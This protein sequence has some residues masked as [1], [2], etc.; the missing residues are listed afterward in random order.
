MVT[1][2]NAV[3][4]LGD[5]LYTLQPIHQYLETPLTAAEET[6]D[7]VRTILVADRGIAYQMFE[8]TFPT[9]QIYDDIDKAI[10]S[11][12]GEDMGIIRLD[13]GSSGHICFTTMQQT[14]K[15][16]HISEGF[17]KILGITLSEPIL[18][19][20]PWCNWEKKEDKVTRIAIAPFSRSCSRHT[21]ELPNK[22]LDDWKWNPLQTFL[23]S[24]SEEIYVI[25]GPKERLNDCPFSEDEYWTAPSF[26]SLRRKLKS[27]SL[28]VTV[29]NGLGHIASALNVPTIILWPQV[30]SKEFIM[31]LWAPRTQYIYGINPNTIRPAEILIGLRK[32]VPA[33]LNMEESNGHAGS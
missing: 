9:W 33:I 13:A 14:Q 11:A 25:G 6:S 26:D 16:M 31:P 21:G 2:I 23:R 5:S 29:D 8:D 32:F 3:N 28:L 22:T 12:P 17:A 20:A 19:Y 27:L 18:P 15:Q 24:H 10:Q 1:I 4:L 30:S 7:G